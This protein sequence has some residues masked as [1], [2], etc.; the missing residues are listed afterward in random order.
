MQQRLPGIAEKR[1]FDLVLVLILAVPAVVACLIAAVIIWFDD[2]ANPFF[3]QTRLGRG[4]SLFRL[5]KLRTMRVGTGD[6]PSHEAGRQHITRIGGLMRRTKLDELPQLWN[7]LR[8]EM[9]FVGPRPGLPSQVELANCRRR[10]GVDRLLPGITGVAQVAGLDM[11]T[12]A[13]LAEK[14]ATYIGP[15][16][17]R[18]DLVLLLQTGLG[19]GRGD[20]ARL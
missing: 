20:A 10:Y 15:W 16:S 1:A 11:S 2:R 7:V 4:G 13:Q 18:R 14:D 19:R 12:P 3:V 17:L 5:V 9:S 8:G 6:R